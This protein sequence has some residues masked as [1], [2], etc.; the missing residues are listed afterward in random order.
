MRITDIKAVYP[1]YRHVAPSWRT[2]FWQIAVRVDTDAGITGWGY[3]GGG[4]ASEHVVNG[5]FRE[6]LLQRPLGDVGD[7]ESIWSDLYQASVPYGRK[8]IAVMAL[9]GVDLALWDLLG[10][11]EGVSVCQLLGGQQRARVRAYASGSDLEWF[12]EQG[13][14]ATKTSIKPN[15]ATQGAVAGDGAS[16]GDASERAVEAAVSWAEK[17]RQQLGAQASLMVDAYMSWTPA[18][19]VALAGALAQFGIYWLEDALPA[20]DLI[21]LAALRPQVKPALLAG[22]EHEFTQHGFDEL[23]RMGALDLWQPDV[24]WCGGLTATRR[25]VALAERTGVPVVLHRGGEV[26]G[27]H[28]IASGAGVEDLAELVIGHR[29]AR[30]DALWLGEPTVAAG[31][32]E[33]PPAAGF[34]V[35]PNPEYL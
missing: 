1:E 29:R 10:R 12:A 32:L 33:L 35:E 23:A 4:R 22:G 27:L 3:G 28:L 20:D 17:A 13:F 21:E 16:G 9:S 30:R 18:L 15:E 7:I 24:T 5:H 34:G 19:T 8:G 31:H 26:W 25:I 14:T 11:A 6:L 2:H